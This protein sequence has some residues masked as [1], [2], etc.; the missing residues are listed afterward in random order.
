MP[1]L[2]QVQ[3]PQPWFLISQAG[4]Q[5][6]PKTGRCILAGRLMSGCLQAINH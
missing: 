5:P 6:R 1:K 3:V 4:R 2:V